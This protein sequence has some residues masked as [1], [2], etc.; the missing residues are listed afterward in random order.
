ALAVVIGPPLVNG[1]ASHLDFS[2]LLQPPSWTH[3]LGTD[4]LGRDILARLIVASRLSI[5]LSI[6][7]TLLGTAIGMVWGS[8]VTLLRGRARAIALRT[9]DAVLAFPA[10]LVAI[11]VGAI[12]GPGSS[13]AT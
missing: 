9:I 6:E 11:F 12:A 7:A 2:Q 8:S 4:A 3:P 13:S 1:P 5:L 10:V